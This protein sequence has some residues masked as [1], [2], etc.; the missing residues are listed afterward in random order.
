MDSATGEV[1]LTFTAV[2]SFLLT[3]VTRADSA[4]GWQS[5]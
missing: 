4:A 2:F 5:R 3:D 1:M